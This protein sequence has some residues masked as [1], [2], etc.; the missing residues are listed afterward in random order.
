[1]VLATLGRMGLVWFGMRERG[2]LPFGGLERQPPLPTKLLL[3][4]HG[5]HHRKVK[6]RNAIK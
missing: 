4:V 2:K 3:I 5:D 1:L 6:T